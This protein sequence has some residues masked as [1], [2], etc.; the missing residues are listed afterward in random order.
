MQREPI[1]TPQEQ[2]TSSRL[3]R[4]VIFL[5]VFTP[6]Y[7]AIVWL[8]MEFGIV[9]LKLD[10]SHN[11][12]VLLFLVGVYIA[13]GF[14][15]Q[16]SSF[17]LYK[18]KLLNKT[19]ENSLNTYFSSHQEDNS[20]FTDEIDMLE[21]SMQTMLKNLYRQKTELI[22]SREKMQELA[23]IT[24]R[25]QENERR[26]ISRELHDQAGQLLVS[27]RYTVQTLL[28]D[29]SP[30]SPSQAESPLNE[31][32]LKIRLSSMLTK[33][34]KTL[35]TVRALSHKMRPG[36]LDV[37]DINLAMQ[38][39]CTEFQEGKKITI[40]YIGTPIPFLTEEPAISLFRFLQEAL[41]N[42]LKHADASHVQVRLTCEN[43]WVQ[44][45]VEDNG[46]GEAAGSGQ[47][48]IG[49]LGMKERFLL[50]NG[51]VDASPTKSGFIITA[52]IP[53]QEASEP[54][55]AA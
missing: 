49:I 6:V 1:T 16:R 50:L 15:N 38:E 41:T 40:N 17:P 37:G 42:V 18:I 53:L 28:S 14:S 32:A 52:K 13:A 45:S 24:L 44:M 25:S 39:Y 10:D 4:W 9:F 55:N 21:T 29:L 30:D 26:H 19:R 23:R 48:G 51:T 7:A 36:L 43:G 33:I 54:Q 5:L 12:L 35:D 47:K 27:L 22:E 20:F 11:S 2:K 34:D 3:T 31:D 8:L 46:R